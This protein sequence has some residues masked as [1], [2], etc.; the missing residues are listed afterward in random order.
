MPWT[1]DEQKGVTRAMLGTWPDTVSTWGREAIAAYVGELEAR[2]LSAEQVLVA[3]RTFPRGRFAPPVPELYAAARVDASMPTYAE[4]ERLIW[5]AGGVLRA[6]P[7]SRGFWPADELAKARKRAQID[8]ANELH[9]C[10]ADFVVNRQT[11]EK[12]RTLN[13]DDPDFGPKR[14]REFQEEWQEHCRSWERREIVA[15]ASGDRRGTLAQLD[16]LAAIG[17]PAPVIELPSRNQPTE[18]AS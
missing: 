18:A 11:I 7:E 5:G 15:L 1:A 2:G 14:R 10:L 8:R 6:R 3:I 9:P 13:F 17:K 12:L 4:V 16:P